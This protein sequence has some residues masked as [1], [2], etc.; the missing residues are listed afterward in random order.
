MVTDGSEPKGEPISTE[1]WGRGIDHGRRLL[2][3]RA[4]VSGAGKSPGVELFGI[5]EAIAMLFALQGARV[6]VVDISASGPTRPSS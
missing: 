2:G 4:L 3:K 1:E 6:S 5:G